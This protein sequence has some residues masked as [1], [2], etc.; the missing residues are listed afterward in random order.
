MIVHCRTNLDLNGEEWPNELP[1]VPAVGDRIRSKMKW[2]QIQLELVVTSVTWVFKC[3]IGVAHQIWLPE[4]EMHLP[5]N[6]DCI[7][8]FEAW[9]QRVKGNITDQMYRDKCECEGWGF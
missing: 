9:Y 1:A 5:P 2:G 8:H 6:F 3:P 7:S 4:I